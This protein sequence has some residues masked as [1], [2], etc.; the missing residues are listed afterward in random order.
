ML[1]PRGA[2]NFCQESLTAAAY[3]G[4]EPPFDA[5]GPKQEPNFRKLLAW[6]T[7]WADI[8]NYYINMEEPQI[9]SM[10]AR[11][12]QFFPTASPLMIYPGYTVTRSPIIH[13]QAAPAPPGPAPQAGA[14]AQYTHSS[15]NP[16]WDFGSP[17][18][19]TTTILTTT[20]GSQA[21]FWLNEKGPTCVS[22]RVPCLCALQ[23]GCAWTDGG[24][25]CYKSG[26]AE[27]VSCGS[28]ALQPK[29]PASVCARSTDPCS[30]VESEGGCRWDSDVDL[31]VKAEGKSTACTACA[32]QSTCHPPKITKIEPLDGTRV[33]FPDGPRAK[34]TIRVTFDKDIMLSEQI[35]V[36]VSFDC[37][38]NGRLK[39]PRDALTISNNILTVPI[40]SVVNT[41][42]V[43]CQL[44]IDEGTVLDDEYLPFLGLE[45]GRYA[46]TLPDTAPPKLLGL[47]PRNGA[48]DVELDAAVVAEFSE[49]ISLIPGSGD[50]VLEDHSRSPPLQ[51]Q[52]SL[53]SSRLEL[54]DA[55]MRIDLA[56]LLSAN[57]LHSLSVPTAAISDKNGNA[58]TSEWAYYEFRTVIADARTLEI[59]RDAAWYSSATGIVTILGIAVGIVCM[60]SGCAAVLYISQQKHKRHTRVMD[61]MAAIES[62]ARITRAE[63]R[64]ESQDSY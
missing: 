37:E 46:F 57:A 36:S 15:Q 42:R 43:S 5:N 29:C 22:W 7:P 40:R 63:S 53:T 47:T 62:E 31:C 16:T 55:K 13:S 52:I 33:D 8:T 12:P 48:L 38:Y 41:F 2:S 35:G 54:L 20:R 60:C 23:E 49:P 51:K 28:C 6:S 64:L 56:D 21:K 30:C 19:T 39:V 61:S 34:G 50:I 17:A 9:L 14:P 25:D 44:M 10:R 11:V 32:K 59:D 26:K 27:R 3:G 4:V 58:L 24:F 1:A 45:P 18:S